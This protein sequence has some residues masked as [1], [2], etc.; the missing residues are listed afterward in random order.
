MSYKL[1]ILKPVH[2]NTVQPA[3]CPF[4]CNSGS[5]WEQKDISITQNI[6]IKVYNKEDYFGFQI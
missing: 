3:L 2:K 6:L 5:Y 4:I 1:Q